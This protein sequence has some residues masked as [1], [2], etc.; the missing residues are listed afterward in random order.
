MN[1]NLGILPVPEMANT[2]RVS[3]EKAQVSSRSNILSKVPPNR[4]LEW[5]GPFVDKNF[6]VAF[7]III[8][9]FLKTLRTI[10]W[11]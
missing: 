5:S 4:A 6:F 8:E 2:R 3:K 10:F 1:V 7:Q 9:P 11:L